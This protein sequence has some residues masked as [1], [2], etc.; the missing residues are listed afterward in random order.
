VPLEVTVMAYRTISLQPP[1]RSSTAKTTLGEDP[2]GCRQRQQKIC[3]LTHIVRPLHAHTLSFE[4]R[5][6]GESTMDHMR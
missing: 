3:K 5:S 1:W 4:C 6:R 2:Q